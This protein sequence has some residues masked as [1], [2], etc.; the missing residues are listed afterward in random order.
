MSVN[1]QKRYRHDGTISIQVFVPQNSGDGQART[2]AEA[3]CSIFRGASFDSI[4]CAAPYVTEG[5][6]EG[7]GWYQ[8]NV[9]CAYY[10]DSF[11]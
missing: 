3:A 8:L 4:R 6:L 11:F 9:W 1:D 10:R 5:G 7:R 2:L